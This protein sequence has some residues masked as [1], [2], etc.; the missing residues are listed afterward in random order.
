MSHK[1]IY[2]ANH[3]N[4]M[5]LYEDAAKSVKRRLFEGCDASKYS[6]VCSAF[7]EIE[8]EIFGADFIAKYNDFER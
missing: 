8:I 5:Y 4:F 2:E 7:D 6:S 3:L 1:A